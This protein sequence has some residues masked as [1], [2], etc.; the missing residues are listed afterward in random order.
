M[1][2]A[3]WLHFAALA[4]GQWRQHGGPQNTNTQLPASGC[5][6]QLSRRLP[7]WSFGCISAGMLPAP[8]RTIA[9]GVVSSSRSSGGTGTCVWQT[10]SRN[11][12][13]VV[14]HRCCAHS[15]R[16][17]HRAAGRTHG[18]LEQQKSTLIHFRNP[19]HVGI[20]LASLRSPVVCSVDRWAA[21]VVTRG[22]ALRGCRQ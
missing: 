14:G 6:C 8:A 15:G 2:L 10:V 1:S 18:S 21:L 19:L 22:S 3:A 13:G 9:S 7:W 5:D 12:S 4:A 17:G 16:T 11:V 20:T